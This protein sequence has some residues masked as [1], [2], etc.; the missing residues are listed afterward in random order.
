MTI[1]L[2][3]IALVAAKLE[4]VLRDL[5]AVFGLARAHIDPGVAVFGLENTLMPVGRNFFEVVAPVQENT[6]AGR[7]L[8]RRG[9]DGGYMVITQTAT[10][11]ELEAVRAQA[12]AA[13]VRVAWESARRGWTLIQL[14]PG[15]L[16]TT[17]LDVEW[18]RAGKTRSGR[19]WSSTSPAWSCRRMILSTPPDCGA[20]SPGRRWTRPGALRRFASTTPS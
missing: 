15:D 12:G 11:A 5:E 10:L 1:Q 6:A 3:Q 19:T 16:K 18:D 7:Y 4:P 14:H 17:F 8:D 9:G 2:R 13:G 20:P